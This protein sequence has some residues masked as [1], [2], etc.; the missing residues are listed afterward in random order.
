MTDWLLGHEPVLR[1]SLFVTLAATLMWLERRRPRRSPQ[2]AIHHRL[3]INLAMPVIATGLIR[4]L[5]PVLPVGVALW[6]AGEQVGLAHWLALPMWIAIPA[7]IIVLD[8]AIYWQHRW[9]HRWPVL[10]RLHRMHHCD[11]DFDVS[12]GVRFHPLEIIVSLLY[13]MLVVVVL[14]LPAA[15][16]LL[17]EVLLNA[18]S[19]FNHANWSLPESVDRRLR[20]LIVTP[21]M[22]RVHH[23]SRREETNSN[24]GFCLPWWDWL[25]GSY[26][27][28]PA[29]G[30]QAMQIG[31]EYYRDD[32]QQRLSRLLL[33]PFGQPVISL[34]PTSDRPAASSPESARDGSPDRGNTGSSPDD[35]A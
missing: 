16:V 32:D 1:L 8:L 21:D 9:M 26:R 34:P 15:G 20:R 28:Q 27:A 13:K 11:V 6:A 4:L 29:A 3:P 10:W 17:F 24:F 5:L 25:F 14:G 33:Q 31:L 19:L 18:T 2:Q 23:S 35:A 12:T 22:H 7:S 30:H